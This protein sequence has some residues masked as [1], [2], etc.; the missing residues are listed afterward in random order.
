MRASVAH[1][2]DTVMEILLFTVGGARYGVALDQVVGV[3][4]V[5]D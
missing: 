1:M 2:K 3:V 5:A 4:Q